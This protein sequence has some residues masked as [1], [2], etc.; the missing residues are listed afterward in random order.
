[1]PTFFVVILSGIWKY[2][3]QHG[4][5]IYVRRDMYIVYTNWMNSKFLYMYSEI[6]IEKV[7]LS[8][9]VAVIQWITKCQKKIV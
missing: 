1:M 5:Q 2:L 6:F 4:I 8:Y 3:I 9:D 7:L